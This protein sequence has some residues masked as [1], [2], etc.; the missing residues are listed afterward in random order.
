MDN[1][2]LTSENL[3]FVG[4]SGISQNNRS[5]GLRPAFL[6][7]NTGRIEIARLA[8]GQSAP[9]HIIN[10][11]PD[12]WA[13]SYKENGTIDSLIDGVIAGFVSGNVFYTREEAANLVAC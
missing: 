9:V 13:N 3:D 8:N 1:R 2:T 6:D 10:W 5:S 4:T 11:L 12:E 7:L